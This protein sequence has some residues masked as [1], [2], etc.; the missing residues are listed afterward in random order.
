VHYKKLALILSVSVG[1]FFSINCQAGGKQPSIQLSQAQNGQQPCI[2]FGKDHVCGKKSESEKNV[3]AFLGIPFAETTEGDNRWAPPISIM[4]AWEDKGTLQATD[5]G[6]ICSQSGQP[7]D[8]NMSEDCLSI[9]VWTPDGRADASL[10][11]MVFI[12]GG[13]FISGGSSGGLYD[14]SYISANQN[15]VVVSF[16]YRV[17]ALGFL[18][19]DDRDVNFEGNY[20]FLDQQVA[21]DWVQKNIQAFG[22][23][24]KNVTIFGESAGAMSVG[25][26]LVSAPK[27]KNL[28]QAG[29]MES[30]L[31]SIPYKDTTQA[32]TLGKALIN[33]TKPI[34]SQCSSVSGSELEECLKNLPVKDVLDAQE[35]ITFV[36]NSCYSKVLDN[37]ILWAPIIDGT[38][39]TKQPWE[40]NTL[41]KPIILGTNTNEGVLFAALNPSSI[42]SKNSQ[43]ESLSKKSYYKMVEAVFPTYAGKILEQPRY[44]YTGTQP[45]GEPLARL[46][47]DYYFTCSSRAVAEKAAEV[48]PNKVYMYLFN[49][50][51]SFNWLWIP[52]CK[53]EVC[54]SAELPFVFHTGS[55]WFTSDE[56]TLSNNMVSYWATFAKNGVPK[57]GSVWPPYSSAQKESMIFETS[58]D[59]PPSNPEDFCPF[60][61]K[62]WKLTDREKHNQNFWKVFLA[63]L[64]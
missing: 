25:L 42:F 13:A 18:K 12:Y 1:T 63:P 28:F 53:D 37:I 7:N 62:F 36:I 35:I 24:P 44:K 38:N 51:P 55:S 60:W 30:N 22:G 46:I 58:S 14:G 59:K 15:S 10:P 6:P 19:F 32:N 17:G 64:E 50:V 41:N 29:I 61:D 16:N 31:Y 56:N 49:H 39:I 47:T 33:R 2:H 21:L 5:Y 23:N 9:N 48:L 34:S 4:A 45:L 8:A 27:S 40:V 43:W 3:D 26:H 20:G 54:H 52:G 57:N 11:V